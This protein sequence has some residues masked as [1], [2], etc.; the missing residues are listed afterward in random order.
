MKPLKPTLSPLL[1]N[2]AASSAVMNFN[3]MIISFYVF[4]S[5]YLLLGIIIANLHKI[6]L[7]YI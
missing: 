4:F 5:K 1:T 6:M 7:T 2:A 3:A